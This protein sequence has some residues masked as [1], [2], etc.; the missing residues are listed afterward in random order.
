MIILISFILDTNTERE[1]GRKAQLSNIEATKVNFHVIIGSEVSFF[2]Q[3]VAD[4]VRTCLGPRAMLKMLMDPM[5]G[6]VLTNDGNAILREI[7]VGHPAAKSM[8][9]LCRSQD[10]EVGDGTT[11]VII[12]AGE[13]LSAAVPFLERNFHPITI[14]AGYKKALEECLRVLNLEISC[15]VDVNNDSEMLSLIGTSLGTKFAS[16]WSDLICK[17]SL[18]AVRTVALPNG[19]IDVKRYVRIEKIPGGDIDDSCLLKGVIVNKDVVHP[20]MRREINNP[21]V[22][23]LDCNLEY[24]KGESQTN[25]EIS[26][27][28]DWARYLE[29]EE[30]QIREMCEY[31]LAV[32][33]DLVICEKGISDL[34]QHFLLKGGVSA[35]RRVKKSDTNRLARACGAT[36]VNRVEDLKES[37]VGLRAGRFHV[38]K[39]GDEYF[40]YV[41]ECIEATAC[42]ILLRGPSKDILNEIDRNLADALAV[43]RNIILQPRLC[44]GGGATEM[45]LALK[46]ETAAS[47]IEGVEKLPFKA[48]ASALEIIPRTLAQNCGADTFRLLTQ[49]RAKH[50]ADPVKNAAV[51]IDGISG[52]LVDYSI[53]NGKEIWE[54]LTVKAQILKTA[55][56]AACMILRVDDIVS[57]ITKKGTSNGGSVSEGAQENHE[58]HN[59]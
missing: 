37:D 35:L 36:I 39:I 57:G 26:K 55:I 20:S 28:S 3:T 16:R 42:T 11:S 34:A 53:K 40:A 58:G 51:G 48:I 18:N 15:P 2:K 47:N 21:R 23:L 44:P 14:I 54:P 7:D 43:A 46:L 32:K 5:G 30:T 12:L 41:D 56:E 24:K 33:P 8:L 38:E 4:I 29:I 59:H 9:E 6:I 13:V 52:N 10:E 49:L 1:S 17:L 27:E 31:I 22:V 50:A 25:I 19:E 45:F